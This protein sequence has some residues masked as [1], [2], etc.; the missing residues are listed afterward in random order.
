MSIPD[1]LR[2]CRALPAC[3]RR[4][5]LA[6]VA[7]LPLAALA[8]SVVDLGRLLAA[9]DR[10]VAARP[11]ALTDP[12]RVASLVAAVAAR[13][14]WTPSCLHRSLVTAWWLARAGSP[15]TLVLGLRRPGERVFDA[16]AWIEVDGAAVEV[17]PA[18]AWTTLLRRPLPARRP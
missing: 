12:A 10:R 11:G 15:C 14:P 13:L 18:G 2:R 3:E 4:L 8:L 1:A 17:L 6:A 16:H 9:L 7:A 5:V